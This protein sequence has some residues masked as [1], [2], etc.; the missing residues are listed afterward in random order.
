M[1]DS[2]TYFSYATEIIFLGHLP[3]TWTPINNGWSM[4]MSFWFSIVNLENTLQYMELQRFTSIILS[5]LTIVPIYFLCKKFFNNKL[6]LIGASIFAFEPRIILNSLLGITE[7]LFI[8]ISTITLVFFL[9][10]ERK[11]IVISFILVSLCT[12]IRSE[13][14]FLFFTLTI[15]FFIKFRFHKKYLKTYLVGLIIF[16]LILI[17][18]INYRIEVTGTDGIFLRAT[19]G[20]TQTLSTLNQDEGVKIFEG[21]KLFISYLSWIMIP[22][23]IIFVPYGIIQF[24]KKRNKDTKFIFVILII[25]SIP[26]FYAYIMQAHDTRYIYVLY[27]IFCLISLFAI[28]KYISKFNQK[29]LILILMIIGILASSI[30]FYEYKKMD[31]EK[32]KEM[33]EIG[34]ITVQITSG[35]NS[36]PMESKY[37][38]AAQIPDDWP[39]IF[40]DD[41]YK[42]KII[43]TNGYDD[44]EKY[45][46]NT[47]NKLTHIIVDDDPNLPEFLKD[48]YKNEEKYVYLKKVFDSKNNGFKYKMKIFEIDY[49]KLDSIN[50]DEF[51]FLHH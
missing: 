39:F 38:R 43:S 47:K 34:K 7:P 42:I 45:I 28:E 17:P 5:S 20:T 22:S 8:L 26:I 4:F 23:F 41:M 37:I 36:H 31:Y 9:K 46:F 40:H 12:I 30:I 50:K 25:N 33:Y 35:I 18:V 48:V 16:C 10:Y 13:G 49:E 44:L 21:I 1:A 32:E 11:E 27:P 15:L 29:N 2:L 24:F 14:I 6:S 51:A 19:Q 3:T